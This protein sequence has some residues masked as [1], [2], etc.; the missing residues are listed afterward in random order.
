MKHSIILFAFLCIVSLTS[1]GRDRLYIEDFDIAAGETL[2]V[3]VI[4]LNDT[5]YCGLQTDLYLPPGLSLDMEYDEYIIDLTSRKHS[6]HTVASRQLSD[7]AIRIYISSISA[8]EFSGNSGPIMTLSITAANTFSGHAV[9]EL[10]NSICAEAIGTRHV[11]GDEICN[12]NPNDLPTLRGDVDGDSKV[13]IDDV[14]A[15]INILLRG[16]NTN[17]GADADLDGKVNIDDVTALINYL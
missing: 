1:L 15:L 6:S 2:Q 17:S 4:L 7:G 11:L 13:N 12:V 14:T 3:P 5:A 9:I 16:D 8:R 10:K